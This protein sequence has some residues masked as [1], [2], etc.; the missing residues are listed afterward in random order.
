M[1]R[2]IETESKVQDYY[3]VASADCLLLEELIDRDGRLVHRAIRSD[4]RIALAQNSLV[5]KYRRSLYET[6]SLVVSYE[7]ESAYQVDCSRGYL[8]IKVIDKIKFAANK[9]ILGLSG[10]VT[11][12]PSDID[13][14]PE[15][16]FSV[17]Y[18]NSESYSFQGP[19]FFVNH[20]CRPNCSYE[21]IRGKNGFVSIK[22]LRDVN[23]GEEI[24]VLYGKNYFG[25]N[26]EFCLCPFKEDHQP[27]A[28]NALP[29]APLKGKRSGK[30]FSKCVVLTES[31]DSNNVSNSLIEQKNS[32]LKI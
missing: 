24:T 30:S 3:E 27:K 22:S 28:I 12:W 32:L 14:T 6:S 11:E 9:L 2:D 31:T 20:S 19:L 1:E 21:T 16:N 5:L 4:Q 8:G 17:F 15:L 10:L 29:C 13:S 18:R 26:K 7:P 23:E 25:S